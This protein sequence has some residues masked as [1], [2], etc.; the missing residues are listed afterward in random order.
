VGNG[1]EIEGLPFGEMHRASIV[2]TVRLA[3]GQP[4]RFL[5][6]THHAG[7]G[8]AGLVGLE[9]P[10]DATSHESAG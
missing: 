9:L 2:D 4:C 10:G 6:V 5:D 8:D 3:D 7:V 1:I